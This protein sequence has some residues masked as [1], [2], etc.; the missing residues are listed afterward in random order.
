MAEIEKRCPDCQ[1]RPGE[2]HL[3]GCDVARCPLCKGQLLSC[4]CVYEVNGLDPATL[5]Q[6]RPDVYH[7]GATEEMWT[8]FDAEV[9][10]RGSYEPWTGEWPGYAECREKGWFC[11]DGFGPDTRWG[12]FCPCPPDA[13]GARPDLNRLAYFHA[14][15]KDEAY[16]GCTRTYRGAGRN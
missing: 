2:M 15:G 8:K 4:S 7:N 1:V 11:Q 10:K 9:K 5:E 14:T 13:H 6:T 12:S 16:K 3:A